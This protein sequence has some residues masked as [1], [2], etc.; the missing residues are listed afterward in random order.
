MTP[1]VSGC[2]PITRTRKPSGTGA[3]APIC[4]SCASPPPRSPRGPTGSAPTLSS[5][6]RWPATWPAPSAR[7]RTRPPSARRSRKPNR[8]TPTWPGS[9]PTS[10]RTCG[11]TTRT[12]ATPPTSP[13][14]R[15]GQLPAA[16][17]ARAGG[18]VMTPERG[19]RGR[20]AGRGRNR[21]PAPAGPRRLRG[22]ARR[23]L[24]R[25]IPASRRRPGRPVEP[26]RPRHRRPRPGRAR[27]TAL[28]TRRPRPLRRPAPRRLPRPGRPAPAGTRNRTRNGGNP[29]NDT[30]TT[31]SDPAVTPARPGHGRQRPG[32]VLVADQ[33]ARTRS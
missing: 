31:A 13:A 4:G 33:L 1:S 16:A 22:R 24:P 29:V 21:L 3:A 32:H 28:G 10:S 26:G 7:W 18:G 11:G 23:R 12:T 2:C 14:P 8:T 25:R 30:Q 20:R 6:R 9:A 19:D 5:T 15:S 17:R 27:G